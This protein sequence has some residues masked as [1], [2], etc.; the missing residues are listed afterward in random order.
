MDQH[1]IPQFYLRGFRD[2][3]VDEKRGPW[4]WVTDLAEGS[5][6]CRSPKSVGHKVDYYAFPEVEAAGL[7][8]IEGLFGKL[9]YAGAP[10]I[11]KLLGNPDAGLVGQD[12][13]DLLFFMAFFVIRVPY[14]RNMMEKF[15]ADTG[16][17][18]LQVA[19][20]HP[21]YFQRTI[22][23]ALKDKGEL[24]AE[25]VEEIREWSLDDSNYTIK[26]SPKLSIAAGFESAKDAI[27]P[28]FCQMN[29]TVVRSGGDLRFL[30]SDTPVTWVDPTLP[31]PYAFGL[32]ARK[33]EVTFPLGPE[34]CLLG[35]WADLPPSVKGK[36]R[37]VEEFNKRRVAFVDRYVFSANEGLARS[38]LALY[39]DS[40]RT[41]PE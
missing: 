4:L 5:V 2:P 17:M 28:V 33:V 22:R 24:T 30:T 27:Y 8:S 15:A 41:R 32:A 6:K 25:R 38:A 39:Q 7:E 11:A 12:K 26:A 9:E 14:F 29:W 34:V 21:D 40:A 23:E 3:A 10:V 20:S 13:A 35:T 19:A 37:V 1:F 16:K 31:P 18:M 36:D